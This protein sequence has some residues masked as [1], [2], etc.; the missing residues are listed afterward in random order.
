[1]SKDTR[2][3]QRFEYTFELSWKTLK[4]YLEAKGVSVQ[5]PRD[6]LK[7]GF[8]AGVLADGEIW[9]E[10]LEKRNV[11]AHTYNETQFTE[12]VAAVRERAARILISRSSAPR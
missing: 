10:M 11:L 8:R 2:W 12:A 1:M 7:E 4:D 5:F 6:A 9:L 3:R